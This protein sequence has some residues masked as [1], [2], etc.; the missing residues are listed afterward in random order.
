MSNGEVD[1]EEMDEEEELEFK[2]KPEL[3]VLGIVS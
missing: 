3:K 1:I 2:D